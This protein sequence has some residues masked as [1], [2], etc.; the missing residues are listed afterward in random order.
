M[1]EIEQGVW[2]FMQN[3]LGY[4]DEE[5]KTFRENPRNADVL[6]KA[7]ALMDKTIV[8]EVVESKGC[9]SQHKVGDKFYF[10]GAGNL[11]TKMNPEKICIYALNSMASPIFV[12][13]ELFYAGVDPN[14]MR[15][16]RA[17]CFDV[18][19]QCG[20]WGQIVMEIRVEDRKK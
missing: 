19:V 11:I 3:H 20:G 8:L 1:T 2:D 5:M 17:S 10:D 18:G 16:K 12:A 15:F 4:S 6:K 13:N 7:A 9:N 14:E